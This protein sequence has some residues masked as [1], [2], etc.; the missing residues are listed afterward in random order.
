[1]PA[2][3]GCATGRSDET[4]G[5]QT[6]TGH[7]CPAST[8][9]PMGDLPSVATTGAQR[10]ADPVNIIDDMVDEWGRQSFPASDPPSK[11]VTTR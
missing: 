4:R 11:L 7:A 8:G 3:H 10:V 2:G 9:G 6:G 1:M 5:A